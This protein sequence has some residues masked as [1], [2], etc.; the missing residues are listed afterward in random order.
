MLGENEYDVIEGFSEPPTILSRVLELT[1]DPT[2]PAEKVAEAVAVSPAI[3]SR[4]L[5]LSN[6]AFYARRT[7][8]VTS[9]HQSVVFLGFQTVRSLI[10]TATTHSLYYKPGTAGQ[11]C[12]RMWKHSLATAI[13]SRVLANKHTVCDPEE[14]YVAGLLHDIGK[15]H[16]LEKF[17]EQFIY[18]V[19]NN[20]EDGQSLLRREEKI[21][22][23]PH[24]SIGAILAEKWLFPERL[25]DAV[26]TH[27]Q[28]I[29][30]ESLS[31]IVGLANVFVT[32]QQHNIHSATAEE[33]ALIEN[34]G[35]EKEIEHFDTLL[36]EQ[37]AVFDAP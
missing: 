20:A 30:L 1:S 31:G 15:L 26:A 8:N 35:W 23:F 14:A 7:R 3:A 2:T 6:S 28:T 18:F 12:S 11:I 22:H 17:P 29:S 10:V 37:L 34:F 33:K 13:F 19:N 16:L 27:H 4:V 5:R 9:I 25:V 36:S 24:P 32:V 21:F